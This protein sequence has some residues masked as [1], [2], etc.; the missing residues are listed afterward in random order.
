MY[1][2]SKYHHHLTYDCSRVWTNRMRLVILLLV[3]ST[4]K[5]IFPR[6]RSHLRIWS[7]E[8]ARPVPHRSPHSRRIWRL[9][10]GASP[11]T[12]FRDGVH[13]LVY[14]QPLSIQSRVY[15]VTQLRTGGV[16]R[17]DSWPVALKAALVTTAL[18]T[19]S[20]SP[21]DQIDQYSP[22]FSHSY[23]S[24]VQNVRSAH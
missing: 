19:Q 11:S 24:S 9:L 15:R 7:R 2:C 5:T 17:R 12:A 4:G 10:T 20:G 1:L 23:K 18:P 14:S 6:P 8:T 16:Q 21:M 13:L 22:L 3:S